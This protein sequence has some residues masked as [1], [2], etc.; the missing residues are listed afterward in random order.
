MSKHIQPIY[1]D[2][3]NRVVEGFVA[4]LVKTLNCFI[5]A[6]VGARFPF[7]GGTMPT[8]RNILRKEILATITN[9]SEDV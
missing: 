2:A 9:S 8:A 3:A 4:C 7:P 1:N 5:E 6:L